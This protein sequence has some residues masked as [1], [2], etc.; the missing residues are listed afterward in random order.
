MSKPE[1]V[2]ENHFATIPH[3]LSELDLR[4][5]TPV[6]G[7][8]VGLVSEACLAIAHSGSITLAKPF[9]AKV[10]VLLSLY[11][12]NMYIPKAPLDPASFVKQKAVYI[13]EKIR[14]SQIDLETASRREYFTTGNASNAQIEAY[15][16]AIQVFETNLKKCSKKLSL[17][18]ENSQIAEIH[19]DML[20][21]VENII[22]VNV[23]EGLVA[24]LTSWTN[25]KPDS[26]AELDHQLHIIQSTLSSFTEKMESNYPMYSDL[27]QPVFVV[28][29]HLK[30]GLKMCHEPLSSSSSGIQ[31]NSELV[32][33]EGSES[34][35]YFNDCKLETIYRCL[36][37][38]S[39][40]QLKWESTVSIL[41]RLDAASVLDSSNDIDLLSLAHPF[42][43]SLVN[44]WSHSEAKK[45]EHRL[46]EE[47]LYKYKEQ[48]SSMLT[49]E[50]IEE[51]ELKKQ[52]PDYFQEFESLVQDS[53][54]LNRPEAGNTSAPSTS[55][56]KDWFDISDESCHKV[57]MMHKRIIDSGITIHSSNDNESTSRSSLDIFEE[58]WIGVIKSS[59]STLH[60]NVQQQQQLGS[61]TDIGDVISQLGVKFML[62]QA[63]QALDRDNDTSSNN[64][65]DFSQYDFYTDANVSQVKSA[66]PM[67]E[68][69]DQRIG[70]LLDRWPEHSVLL[71][72]SKVCSRIASFPASSPLPRFMTG[73]ELL[74]QKCEDWEK[75]A[76]SEVSL[77]SEMDRISDQIVKWRK[78]E[79]QCW[80]E[81]LGNED[82]KYHVK[83]SKLWFHLYQ[84]IVGACSSDSKVKSFKYV[85]L[86][87]WR[88][89]EILT[90]TPSS[91]S[92]FSLN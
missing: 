38:L 87:M 67:L 41:S 75:Y 18:P 6:I 71:N 49:E 21:L 70:H 48:V 15:Q 10:Q 24:Q 43:S 91:V 85:Q 54:D 37:S 46:Q 1:P 86:W 27:L 22:P 60:K 65:R 19:K 92:V 74:L 61:T 7:S 82:R 76:S 78:L 53:S 4:N 13:S 80:R 66:L 83:S 25:K 26:T 88:A 89:N 2:P 20:Q 35:T 90:H 23:I 31:L 51:N 14:H 68:L 34:R 40:D 73:I 50:D 72:L 62:T 47:E 64:S 57:R 79:L 59:F 81:L 32:S 39:S 45:R 5:T 9:L 11:F 17:R 52:F 44:I 55:A 28:V 77:K 3:L 84:I 69:F 16:S 58:L 8:I 36:D 42:F 12:L 29:Y 56:S 33:F 30:N 63:R